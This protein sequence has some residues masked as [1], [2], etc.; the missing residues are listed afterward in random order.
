LTLDEHQPVL[1]TVEGDMVLEADFSLAEEATDS[2]IRL[3]RLAEFIQECKHHVE[4][5]SGEA[6]PLL[7]FSISQKVVE[8][9]IY[10]AYWKN[11]RLEFHM[12]NGFDN[13]VVGARFLNQP[14]LSC[15]LD[16]FPDGFDPF[17][18]L[19]AWLDFLCSI[20]A[21]HAEIWQIYLVVHKSV[22]DTL[23]VPNNSRVFIEMEHDETSLTIDGLGAMLS[24]AH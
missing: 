8:Q 14:Q 2:G 17:N 16:L 21:D 24:P 23:A 6:S 9:M 22:Y 10:L 13:I 18:E 11:H 12:G 7:K 15:V 1:V 20:I 5:C 3:H 4:N 19:Q